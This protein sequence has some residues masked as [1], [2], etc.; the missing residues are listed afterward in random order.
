MEKRNLFNIFK[1]YFLTG[2]LV[3]TPI[4]VTIFVFGFIFVKIDNILGG[5]FELLL[6]VHIPGLGF[7]TLLIM[8]IFAGFVTSFYI[9]K[10]LLDVADSVFTKLPIAK[11]VY[12]TV[13]QLQDLIKMRKS[14]VFH[15]TVLFEYPRKGLWVI[16]FLS[17]IEPIALQKDTKNLYP[18][19]LPTT[20]NPTSGY[21]IFASEN[22]FTVLDIPVEEAMK[23]IVSAGIIGPFEGTD[24]QYKLLKTHTNPEGSNSSTITDTEK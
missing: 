23:M 5:F 1:R 15:N 16:G 6:G 17:S 13:K 22:E 8:I 2:L 12:I 18:I 14:I 19:F 4:M 11:S 24:E 20:P 10:K 7:L 9:G 21:L 3:L